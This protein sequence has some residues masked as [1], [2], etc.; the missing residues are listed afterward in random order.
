M[1]TI[2]HVC[3]SVRGYLAGP[4]SD[5]RKLFRRDGKFLTPREAREVLMQH[6][7]EGR[8]VLP[9]GEPCEGFDF[10]GNG[11]PGHEEVP[12]DQNL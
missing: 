5:L 11:C 9:I 8:E 3:L 6:L 4:D 7:A 2:H 12:H 10:K 1:S